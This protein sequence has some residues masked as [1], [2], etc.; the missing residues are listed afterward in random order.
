VRSACRFS[1]AHGLTAV[2][3]LAPILIPF[4]AHAQAATE[5]SQSGGWATVS[6]SIIGPA[7]V[8]IALIYAVIRWRRRQWSR[9][10]ERERE[11]KIS[12]QIHEGSD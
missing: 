3:S 11:K 4:A 10:F 5:E 9:S 8:A 7:L 2:L 1:W 6:M 12:K